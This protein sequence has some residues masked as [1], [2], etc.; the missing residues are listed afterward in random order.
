MNLK[1]SDN[2]HLILIFLWGVHIFIFS[3]RVIDIK[4]QHTKRA[5]KNSNVIDYP[6]V[7]FRHWNNLIVTFMKS[8]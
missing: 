4:G 8:K 2:K 5:V 6:D 7:H 1:T 3:S